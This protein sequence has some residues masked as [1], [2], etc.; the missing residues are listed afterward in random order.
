MPKHKTNP[1][2]IL[3]TSLRLFEEL[4]YANTTM[5]DIADECGVYKGSIYHFF[6]SKSAILEAIFDDYIKSAERE[7]FSVAWNASLPQSTRIDIF[8]DRYKSQIV[9]SGRVPL[10]IE[11]VLE[12]RLS[13]EVGN[14]SDIFIRD[15]LKSLQTLINDQ[16]NG[17]RLL[18]LIIGYHIS[19]ISGI[20]TLDLTDIRLLTHTFA[21][22]D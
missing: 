14:L 16:E 9:K 19:A 2:D 22:R 21:K 8:F 10:F 4:G 1:E 5:K 13:I 18:N 7:I 6:P 3:S 12:S 15:F 17:K 11:L 20:N